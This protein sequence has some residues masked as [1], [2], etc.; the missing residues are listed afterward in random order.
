MKIWQIGMILDTTY[1][2][3]FA[4]TVANKPFGT[5]I[6]RAIYREYA[7][8]VIESERRAYLTQEYFGRRGGLPK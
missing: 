6:S 3:S 1:N 7:G 4:G 2:S 5:E 8:Y